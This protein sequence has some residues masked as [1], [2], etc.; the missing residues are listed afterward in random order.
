MILKA[1]NNPVFLEIKK[2]Y[3]FFNKILR[4]LFKKDNQ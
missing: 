1:R 3:H 2:E 4:H